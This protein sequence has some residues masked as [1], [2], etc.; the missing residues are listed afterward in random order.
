MINWKDQARLLIETHV[1][2]GGIT[3]TKIMEAMKVIPRH[4]FIPEKNREYSYMDRPLSIGEDQT[5][6]QPYIVAKM[7]ELLELKEG[8]RVLEIGTGSGYQAALLAVMGMKVTTI[9]RIQKLADK[10]RETFKQLSYDIHSITGDGRKGYPANAPYQG[11]I[12]TA[13]TGEI[14]DSWFSQLAEGGR[15][16]LPLAG[17]NGDY[18][19]LVR[20][21]DLSDDKGYKDFFYDNCRFVPLLS[22]I[23][24]T[25]DSES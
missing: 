18:R 1:A 17:E 2:G 23:K 21:K 13:G 7:T 12:V 20:K 25:N 6:S 8:D 14:E 22:G 11:I 16:V 4:L 24:R 10:A 5:I 3:N 9:E 19:L 15:I